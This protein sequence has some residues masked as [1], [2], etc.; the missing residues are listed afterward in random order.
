MPCQSGSEII[1]TASRN[2]SLAVIGVF[3]S[4]LGGLSVLT[5]IRRAMPSVDLIY[6]ADR[7][8]APYGP[9][10]LDEVREISHE[11][12]GWL[13]DRPVETIVIACNTASAAAL[14]TLRVD[15]RDVSFVGMEPAVKPAAISTQSGVIGVLATAAT[16]QGR[17]FR[18]VVSR[19]AGESRV[20]ERACP[21][22]VDLVEQGQI[23]GPLV[24]EAIREC[25]EP[26]LEEGADPL[27]IGCTHFSFLKPA[28]TRVT[29]KRARVIDPGPAVAAQAARVTRHPDGSG[30]LTLVA[31]G[32]TEEFARL[33]WSVAGVK[34]GEPV[35]P[36]PS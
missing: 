11:L 3:D 26:L 30:R 28:I 19:Y 27:V 13:V 18:S 35:L 8:R 15:F 14:E 22:W 21:D 29:G 7:A 20:V 33:A 6:L 25:V 2:G 24:E 31:S 36:F 23:D 4:G 5:E 9:R 17:L 16:F 10:S 1:Q 32:D 12:A 34:T